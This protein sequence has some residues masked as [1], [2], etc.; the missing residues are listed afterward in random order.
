MKILASASV[1]SENRLIDADTTNL[2]AI[3][4]P[5]TDGFPMNA[6]Y[7][8]RVEAG[9]LEL[10]RA[11]IDANPAA[12]RE[13]AD[14]IRVGDSRYAE[15]YADGLQRALAARPPACPPYCTEDHRGQVTEVDGFSIGLCHEVVIADLTADEPSSTTGAAT[16]RVLVESTSERGE[17][18][19]PTRVVLT[20]VE[21]D[22]GHYAGGDGVQGWSGTPAE[23]EQLAHA[24]LSAARIA[25]AAR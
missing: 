5:A 19:T 9:D 13:L 23:V 4:R 3:Q 12:V 17:V 6:A 24:L 20:L 14:A 7:A 18:T 15:G 1:P 10:I 22:T 16:A 8:G 21:G 11:A 25:R 2:T